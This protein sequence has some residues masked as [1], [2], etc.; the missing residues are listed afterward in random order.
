[1]I[2]KT[3]S[4]IYKLRIFKLIFLSMIILSLNFK[5]TTIFSQQFCKPEDIPLSDLSTQELYFRAQYEENIEIKKKYLLAILYRDEP[6]FEKL[7]LEELFPILIYQKRYE[8]I[9]ALSDRYLIYF[10]TDL[11]RDYFLYWRAKALKYLGKLNDAIEIYKKLEEDM[12]ED[13]PLYYQSLFELANLYYD[14]NQYA[15]SKVVFRRIVNESNDKFL[16]IFS[17][18]K[19]IKIAFSK[20]E[21]EEVKLWLSQLQF[22][23]LPPYLQNQVSDI[24]KKVKKIETETHKKS[25]KKKSRKIVYNK[26]I[27]KI[28]AF[29]NIFEA[30]IVRDQLKEQKIKV[31]VKSIKRGRRKEYWVIVGPYKGLKFIK[32]IEDKL[33][34]SLKTMAYIERVK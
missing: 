27:L 4:L 6:K 24:I 16:E 17:L 9:L 19:L 30:N 31:K 1:M 7:A 34:P 11:D 18:I 25:E 2:P 29:S 13:S 14:L 32:N 5:I 26:F 15:A 3:L 33:T 12:T 23:E 21:F 10:S 22:A 8:E 28:G 20:N